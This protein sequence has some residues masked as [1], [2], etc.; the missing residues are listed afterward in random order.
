LAKWDLA[1]LETQL[2]S[3]TAAHTMNGGKLIGAMSPAAY[4]R[5]QDFMLK[6]GI[7]KSTKP[8]ESMLYLKPGFV[9][10]INKFDR[11]AVIADAKACKGL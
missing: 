9:E 8:I 6:D 2:E 3:M 1:L 10:A 7:I 5:M 11:N 4:G